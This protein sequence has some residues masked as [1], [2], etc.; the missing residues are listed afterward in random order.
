MRVRDRYHNDR[1][2]S[3]DAWQANS[4][5][6]GFLRLE[7]AVKAHVCI[8]G[9][10]FAGIACAY[11]LIKAGVDAVVVE[12]N[13]V[14]W[15]ASGRISNQTKCILKSAYENTKIAELSKIS[16]Q[17]R[18]LTETILDELNIQ[19]TVEEGQLSI[20]RPLDFLLGQ[21]NAVA[22]KGGKIFEDA[23]VKVIEKQNGDYWVK[24]DTGNVIAKEVIVCAGAYLG[25][26][27]TQL[28][29]RYR[30]RLIKNS[31]VDETAGFIAV[32]KLGLPDVGK[33]E[34]GVYYIQG[35]GEYGI[36]DAQISAKAI[37]EAII[38]NHKLF[39][40]ISS[41]SHTPYIRRNFTTG[42]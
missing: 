14:G 1:R 17:V 35:L 11:Q 18:L 7:G 5:P 12:Q 26:L 30:P 22:E 39:N 38:G 27:D 24:T 42:L 34:T 20:E 37:S 15:G 31:Q 19:W 23:R 32:N 16:E 33:T 4:L 28:R 13:Q 29:K 36:M 41:P 2:V 40:E 21:A 9:A 3:S 25:P 6:T 10:G 8:I